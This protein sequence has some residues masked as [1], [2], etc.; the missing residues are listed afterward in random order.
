MTC[1]ESCRNERWNDVM[2]YWKYRVTIWFNFNHRVRK[3]QSLIKRLSFNS[4]IHT[5]TIFRTFLLRFKRI[6]FNKRDITIIVNFVSLFVRQSFGNII[7]YG[8]TWIITK[9]REIEGG[10][11]F[12]I[13][14]KKK[15]DA[16][17]IISKKKNIIYIR[18][19]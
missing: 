16:L 10:F 5:N 19:E 14:T 7:I 11:F 15:Y 17:Q 3:S 18:V 12:H 2:L 1:T 8:I 9:K 13:Y 6:R 4:V